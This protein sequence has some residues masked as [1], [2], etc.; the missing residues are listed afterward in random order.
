MK[1]QK[2]K[3]KEF[4]VRGQKCNSLSLRAHTTQCPIAVYMRLFC[5]IFRIQQ[6]KKNMPQQRMN[7]F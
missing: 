1:K 4:C 2:Q 5:K 7:E 3:Q 6:R